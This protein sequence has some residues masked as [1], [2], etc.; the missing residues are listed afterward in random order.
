MT[1]RKYPIGIPT[2]SEIIRGGNRSLFEG[3]KIMSLVKDWQSQPLSLRHPR[4]EKRR[5]FLPG[6]DRRRGR[7][8]GTGGF[9]PGEW[10]R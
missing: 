10:P 2:F 6:V 4:F 1:G 8:L 5:L 7:P 3:L 9:L